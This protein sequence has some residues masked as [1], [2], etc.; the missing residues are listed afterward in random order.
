M[1]V[2]VCNEKEVR[3]TEMKILEGNTVCGTTGTMRRHAPVRYP[4]KLIANYLCHY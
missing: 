2:H 1:L 4:K 3:V